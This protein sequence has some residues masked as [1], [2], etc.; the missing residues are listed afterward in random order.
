EAEDRVRELGG[1]TSSSVSR[2]TSFVVTGSSPGSKLAKAVTLGVRVIDEKTFLDLIERATRGER[3]E[4]E[5]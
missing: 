2:K 4:V 1:S 3:P 5:G